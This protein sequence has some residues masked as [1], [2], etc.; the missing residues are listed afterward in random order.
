VKILIILFITIISFASNAS[1]KQLVIDSS[2]IE[3]REPSESSITKFKS[4]KEFIY[5][6]A[7]TQNWWDAFWT[8]VSSK[9]S[10]L[11]GTRAFGFFQEYLG[12]I[13]ILAA[14]IIIILVLNKSK[15]RGLFYLSKESKMSGFKELKD[16]INEINFDNLIAEAVS[17][18]NY[19]IAVR[20]YYLKSLKLLSDRK[21]ID[22]KINKTNQNYVKEIK[23]EE[24]KK[25]FEELTN[26]FEWIWYGEMPIAESVF[27]KTKNNFLDFQSS[28]QAER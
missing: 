12:Y 27:V 5:D 22:W 13:I 2:K 1:Y 28:L 17:N 23:E 18:S 21:L 25:P 9:L 15:F 11:M 10:K 16:D 14:V 20:L 3:V 19:R 7:Q 24:L 8:W 6:E 4:D 26:M